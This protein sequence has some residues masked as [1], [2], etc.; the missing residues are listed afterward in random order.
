MKKINRRRFLNLSSSSAIA[1]LIAQCSNGNTQE[2]F[3]TFSSE[4]KINQ[5][6]DGLLEVNLIASI[7]KINLGNK[8]AY[9]L[10]YNGQIPGPRL[11]AKPGDTI[12]INFTNKL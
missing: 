2:K 12:R 3:Q 11:E 6:Q 8:Q 9:A 7:N 1:V 4:Y 5:S 10:N